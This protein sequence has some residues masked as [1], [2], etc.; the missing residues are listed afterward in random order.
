MDETDAPD[1]TR[2]PG[3]SRNVRVLGFLLFSCGP[4]LFLLNSRLFAMRRPAPPLLIVP[5]AACAMAAGG[6]M[7]V[8]GTERC[9]VCKRRRLLFPGGHF[10]DDWVCPDCLEPW[11]QP[12][13]IHD[14]GYCGS[15]WKIHNCYERYLASRPPQ[16]GRC[17]HCSAPAESVRLDAGQE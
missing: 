11:E 13:V 9:T 5:L 16:A 2:S 10:G 3:F 7:M 8:M 1:L 17:P 14:C 6:F 15:S 4:L 12:V